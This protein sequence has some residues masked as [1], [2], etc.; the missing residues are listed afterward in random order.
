MKRYAPLVLA[1]MSV[2]GLPLAGAGETGRVFDP[3]RAPKDS[4]LKSAVTLDGYHHWAPPGDLETWKKRRA[5]LRRQILVAA[6]L[7][8]LPPRTA[9]EPVIHGKI[10]REDYTIEKVFFQSY[11]GFYVTGNLYRP[12]GG[13]EKKPAVLS[14]H[15]HWRDGRLHERPEGEAKKLVAA[16]EEKTLE[17]ARYHIQARCAG[18]ARLGCVVFHY[19][20]VGY[21]DSRQIGHRQGFGDVEAELR[22]E[23]AFGLQTWNTL[24]ALD[25][26]LDL[27]DVDPRR[28]GVTGASGGGTQTFILCAIDGRPAVGF[29]AVMVSTGMQGGCVCENASHLR[30]ATTNVEFAAMAAPR[31]YAMTGANDWTKE[32]LTKGLPELK[33]LYKLHGQEERVQAWCHTEFDHNYN[34]VSREHMYD[35]FNRHLELGHPSP[36]NE[37][38]FRPVKP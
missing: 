36:V 17:S 31:P 20:M 10:D 1:L 11:P 37:R 28:V 12:K 23:S 8:P 2:V 13:G 7:W 9:L 32:I 30:V 14:P 15:G 4:R 35:W 16:G 29:P 6:G 33:A 22:L 19:D 24:R 3:P 25:F 18:L 5:T 34:Q 38:P 27:P 21:A 26:L